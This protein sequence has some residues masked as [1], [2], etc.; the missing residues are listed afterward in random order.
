MLINLACKYLVAERTVMKNKTLLIV[1]DEEMLLEL[2]SESLGRHF[3]VIT[4]RSGNKA[5]E[6]IITGRIDC[7]TLDM[8]LPDIDGVEILKR[9]R[10]H[11]KSLPVLVVTGK[12]CLEYA[13]KCADC[14]VSAYIKKPFQMPDLVQR[15]TE[16]FTS[17]QHDK[18]PFISERIQHPKLK[19]ALA[20][21]Q[22]NYCEAPGIES[23]AHSLDVSSGY[24]SRLFKK[25][26]GMTFSR[27]LNRLR[28]GK[29]KALLKNE[30]ITIAEVMTRAGFKTEQHFFKEFKRVT[31][32][33]PGSCRNS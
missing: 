31:G 6:Q 5:L 13:E 27:Y 26:L 9:L 21:I 22:M 18:G 17:I 3:N 25:E 29:A 11:D 16:L 23:L 32:M 7:V 12:S 15:I 24:L 8:E 33:T 28:V 20:C 14:G 1:D 30:D 2:M 19:K 10:H 4:A